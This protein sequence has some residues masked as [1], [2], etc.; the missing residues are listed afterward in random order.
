VVRIAWEEQSYFE[1]TLSFSINTVIFI[2][3]FRLLSFL[4]EESRPVYEQLGERQLAPGKISL[5][6]YIAGGCLKKQGD[7]DIWG[8]CV[9]KDWPVVDCQLM[10]NDVVVM[11]TQEVWY[12]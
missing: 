3:A 1:E 10:T 9:D 4:S 5:R 8:M 2:T 11:T 7:Y 6:A 12:C